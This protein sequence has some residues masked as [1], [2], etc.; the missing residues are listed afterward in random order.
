MFWI[1]VECSTRT[2]RAESDVLHW[3]WVYNYPHHFLL[4]SA[5]IYT[6][7]DDTTPVYTDIRGEIVYDYPNLGWVVFDNNPIAANPTYSIVGEYSY[8]LPQSGEYT[9]DFPTDSTCQVNGGVVKGIIADGKY[10]HTNIIDGLE[11]VFTDNVQE[12]NQAFIEIS[13]AL[14][15]TWY[16]PDLD[17]SPGTYQNSDLTLASIASGEVGYFWLKQAPHVSVDTD[18]NTREVEAFAYEL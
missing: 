5:D 10:I 9:L 8:K 7:S 1:R 17:D 6:K 15:Y 4:G 2:T 14:K 12:L 16:A 13:D 3:T 18:D 11:L